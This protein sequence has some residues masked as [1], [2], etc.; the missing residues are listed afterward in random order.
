M[1]TREKFKVVVSFYQVVTAIPVSY[2]VDFDVKF[3]QILGY[4]NFMNL[5]INEIFPVTCLAMFDYYT[6]YILKA[7]APLGL[8]LIFYGL[9]TMEN[10]LTAEQRRLVFK[11]YLFFL[12]AIY[13]A[14]S[15]SGGESL[16]C[17]TTTDDGRP[18]QRWLKVDYSV[19]C[20]TEKHQ[21]FLAVDIA[22][23]LLYSLG[24]PLYF[25]VLLWMQRDELQER[26]DRLRLPEHLYHLEALCITYERRFW[27]F[28]VAKCLRKYILV[29]ACISIFQGYPSSAILAAVVFCGISLLVFQELAPY[30]FDLDDVL[31]YTSH[32]V[33]LIIFL[34]AAYTRFSNIIQNI[35]SVDIVDN[36][37]VYMWTEL[38]TV[39]S[40]LVLFIML[41]AFISS[42]YEGGLVWQEMM[43]GD[44]SDD[45]SQD[46]IVRDEVAKSVELELAKIVRRDDDADARAGELRQ[47]LSR[48]KAELEI[49]EGKGKINGHQ[50]KLPVGSPVPNPTSETQE[51]DAERASRIAR[52]TEDRL[53]EMYVLRTG[54]GLPNDTDVR[55]SNSRQRKQY[56]DSIGD[57]ESVSDERVVNS[58][59]TGFQDVEYDDESVSDV[60]VSDDPDVVDESV[61]DIL[62][63]WIM[64]DNLRQHDNLQE[65]WIIQLTLNGMARSLKRNAQSFERHCFIGA[66]VNAALSVVCIILCNVL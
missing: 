38:V 28:E 3:S 19:N 22:C 10:W 6:R 30:E 2:P 29:S 12:F 44:F 43:T 53:R 59:R 5:Q 7:L 39:A 25:F 47:L 14:M 51:T 63:Q 15:A 50:A 35:S 61:S 45:D 21:R 8:S 48:I 37:E 16:R 36:E 18:V 40:Y 49:L 23:M 13:P 31:A 65:W 34:L 27:W 24:I 64:T 57:D 41:L 42:I 55:A 58:R 4:F 26:K 33:L 56:D 46:E 9:Y 1:L 11:L 20:D 62:M 17:V 52:M 60:S 32:C 66:R 54:D